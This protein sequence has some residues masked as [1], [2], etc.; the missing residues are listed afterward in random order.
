MEDHPPII[1]FNLCLCYAIGSLIVVAQAAVI[2]INVARVL[3]SPSDSTKLTDSLSRNQ[4]TSTLLQQSVHGGADSVLDFNPIGFRNDAHRNCIQS[5][6][7]QKGT[8][9]PLHNACT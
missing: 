7:Y 2:L 5:P 4:W 3:S 1:Q 6:C 9:S 8:K